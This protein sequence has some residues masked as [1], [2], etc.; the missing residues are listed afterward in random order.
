MFRNCK[1][2]A[3]IAHG[4]IN[5]TVAHSG[6]IVPSLLSVAALSTYGDHTNG[7]DEVG[8]AMDDPG[9]SD[10]TKKT[11]AHDE[12]PPINNAWP[13][14]PRKDGASMEEQ[15]KA[16]ADEDADMEALREAMD[17]DENLS[18]PPTE[19]M[20]KDVQNSISAAG[21]REA[22]DTAMKRVK[23]AFKRDKDEE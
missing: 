19:D 23:E 22:T 15:R 12:E 16:E 14:K 9:Q 10:L 6:G 11:S 2:L 1:R 13:L 7:K 4:T 5:R 3:T 20:L 21:I 18:R 8:E 17:A